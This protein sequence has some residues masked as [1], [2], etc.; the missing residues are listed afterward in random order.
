MLSSDISICNFALS[1]I[2]QRP[3]R[4][5][6]EDNSRA[7]LCKNVYSTSVEVVLSRLDWAFARW[8]V[9]LRQ[10]PEVETDEGWGAYALPADFMSV[11]DIAPFHA[12]TP[13][14]QMGNYLITPVV[15]VVSLKYTR[16]V[17]DVSKFA[18]TF[19]NAVAKLMIAQLAGPLAGASLKEIASFIDAFEYELNNVSVID[20]SVGSKQAQADNDPDLDTFNK[21]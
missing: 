13:F 6:D 14:E 5:F 12:N 4:S 18:T 7:R 2:G 10:D 20:A 11:I 19:K 15:D 9:T 21:V 17:N 8:R 16:R 3:I 1:L